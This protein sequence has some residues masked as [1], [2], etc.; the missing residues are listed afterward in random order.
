[1]PALASVAPLIRHAHEHFD[2]GGYPDGIARHA[3]PLASRIV[4]ACDAYHAMRSQRPYRAARTH[5]AAVHELIGGSGTQ[6]DPTVVAAL[7]DVL[8]RAVRAAPRP[9]DIEAWRLTA[10]AMEP[11]EAGAT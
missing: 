6:F 2:G 8:R 3:I 1:V 7:L 5:E 9:G 10:I 4:L 11:A